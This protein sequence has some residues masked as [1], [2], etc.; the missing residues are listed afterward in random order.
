M[1]HINKYLRLNLDSTVMKKTRLKIK[2]NMDEELE[3]GQGKPLS[4]GDLSAI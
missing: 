4:G 3:E 2:K 1:K